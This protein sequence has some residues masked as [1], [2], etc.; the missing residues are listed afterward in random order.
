M[1]KEH[2]YL[3]GICIGSIWHIYMTK[4]LFH[5]SPK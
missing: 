3:I 4:L 2:L 5:T 1:N